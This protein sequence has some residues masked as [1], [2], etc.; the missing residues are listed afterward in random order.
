M[1]PVSDFQAGTVWET[2]QIQ[3]PQ[4][5]L[6]SWKGSRVLG[7]SYST[8]IKPIALPN[9]PVILPAPGMLVWSDLTV[10]SISAPFLTVV[11]GRTCLTLSC[12]NL[13]CDHL[14]QR[15][16]QIHPKSR[17]AEKSIIFPLQFFPKTTPFIETKLPEACNPRNLPLNFLK[18]NI[19]KLY[20]QQTLLLFR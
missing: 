2:F 10:R 4:T 1:S 3:I 18:L 7:F 16:Y 9:I 14:Q 17:T 6:L 19:L 5:Q 15:Q 20:K 12:I 11:Q 8:S 13:F